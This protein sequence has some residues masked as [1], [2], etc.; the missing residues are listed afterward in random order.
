MHDGDE[1][2]KTIYDLLFKLFGPQKWWPG[3][4]PFEVIVGAILTQN[5]NW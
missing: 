1:Q 2:L 5:T 3:D 4:T